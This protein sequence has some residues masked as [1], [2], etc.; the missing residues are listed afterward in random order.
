MSKYPRPHGERKT[1]VY[2]HLPSGPVSIA[3]L[4]ES[5]SRL[6]SG[7]AGWSDVRTTKEA[8]DLLEAYARG[9]KT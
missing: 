3:D 8:I 6:T 9:D 1:D 2:I 4:R 5:L 7:I